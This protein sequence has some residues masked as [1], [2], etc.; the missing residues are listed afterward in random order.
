MLSTSV[1]KCNAW[2]L[3]VAAVIGLTAAAS[4]AQRYP[5]ACREWN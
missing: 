4:A 5:G 1:P 3:L 2:L